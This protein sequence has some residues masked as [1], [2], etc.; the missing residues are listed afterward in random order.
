MTLITNDSNGSGGTLYVPQALIST[1]QSATNWSTILGYAN[2][3]ILPIEGSIYENQYADGTPFTMPATILVDNGGT[4]RIQAP[5][6]AT[7]PSAPFCC[8][9]N[10]SIGVANLVKRLAAL[11]NAE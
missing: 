7:T 2:N 3:Q 9:S 4:E 8:D 6:G 10:Y 5:E 1:Y 11:E